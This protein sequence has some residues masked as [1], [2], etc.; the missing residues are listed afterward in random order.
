VRTG[1]NSMVRTFWFDR[2]GSL[3]AGPRYP[4]CRF[5]AGGTFHGCATTDATKKFEIF[6]WRLARSH[7]SRGYGDSAEPLSQPH[8]CGSVPAHAEADG[9]DRG[10]G[11]G[12]GRSSPRLWR[13]LAVGS[14]ASR[15]PA[16]LGGTGAPSRFRIR[17]PKCWHLPGGADGDGDGMKGVNSPADAVLGRPTTCAS[18]GPLPG[19]VTPKPCGSPAPGGM[20]QEPLRAVRS[21]SRWGSAPPFPGRLSAVAPSDQM[22]RSATFVAATGS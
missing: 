7:T 6:L 16:A 2:R 17:P 1:A 11:P 14:H 21:S 18:F 4:R 3:R 13:W 10:S 12:R 19:R 22:A 15:W 9:D 20:P 8:R 5:R